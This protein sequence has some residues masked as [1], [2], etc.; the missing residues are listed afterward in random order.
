MAYHVEDEL[1]RLMHLKTHTPHDP[2]VCT[3]LKFKTF[4]QIA[5]FLLEN[6]C[7]GLIIPFNLEK[8]KTIHQNTK[9]MSPIKAKKSRHCSRLTNQQVPASKSR[10][11]SYPGGEMFIL[12][13]R[14]SCNERVKIRAT[15]D[16]SSCTHS[17]PWRGGNIWQSNMRSFSSIPYCSGMSCAFKFSK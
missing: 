2:C 1:Y 17:H 4:A 11:R 16:D 12:K 14:V 9:G 5:S 3:H 13:L 6:K 7:I 8:N 15:R 10:S